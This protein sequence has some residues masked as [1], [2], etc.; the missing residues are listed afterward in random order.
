MRT[1]I[2]S[3]VALGLAAGAASGSR[4]TA[5]F[6]PGFSQVGTGPS[7]GALYQGTFPSTVAQRPLRAGY[8]YL[9][10]GFTAS[11]RYPVVYLLHGMPGGPQEY[12]SSLDIAAVADGLI[13]RGRTRPFIAVVPAAGPTAHYNGEWAGPWE[14]Y[15]ID[16][17]LPWV[18]AHLPTLATRSA[19]TIAGLSAGGYGAA[20]IGLR[21]P[22][23]FGTIESWSGYFHP[24]HDG[25]FKHASSQALAANDPAILAAEQAPALRRLGM[26]IF[27]GSG[28]SHSHWFKEQESVDFAHELQRLGV[29]H[30]L[31]LE[32]DRGHQY[33]LQLAAGLVWALGG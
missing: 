27:V 24:L 26:R 1:L 23:L 6:L 21:A 31:V 22:G 7:G 12:L 19:R 11:A 29:R 16:D 13:A 14:R 28:P 18:D 8:V 25:P 30:T 5:P 10:P 17:V 32:T 20:D 33:G 15:L 9:P 4:G 3:L 2:V